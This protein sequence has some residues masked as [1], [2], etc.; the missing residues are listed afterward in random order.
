MHVL[1]IYS[2][3]PSAIVNSFVINPGCTPMKTSRT[4]ILSLLL[5]V[6]AT[7]PAP[8]D[9]WQKLQ[10]EDLTVGINSDLTL[11]VYQASDTPA[12]ETVVASRPAIDV[13]FA[14]DEAAEKPQRFFLGDAADRVVTDY[15]DGSRTGHRIRLSGL[16][17]TDV[18]VELVFALDNNTLKNGGELLVQVAQVGGRDIVQRVAGLYDWTLKSAADAH[19]MVGLLDFHLCRFFL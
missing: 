6:L 10:S 16:P 18:E 19:T 3:N 8:A 7:G 12:W 17:S 14:G 13:W 9:D 2:W 4:S 11:A 1:L 15:E 5:I